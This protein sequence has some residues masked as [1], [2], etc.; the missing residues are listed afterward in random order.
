[1][2]HM[3]A[4][5]PAPESLKDPNH[6][7]GPR[8]IITAEGSTPLYKV[9]QLLDARDTGGLVLT[10]DGRPTQYV[11][12]SLLASEVV[13]HAMVGI[14]GVGVVS[15]DDIVERMRQLSDSHISDVIEVIGAHDTVVPIDSQPVH[16]QT[17]PSSLKEQPDRVFRVMDGDVLVGWYLNRKTVAE[18][19]TR[20]V[21]FVCRNGH[22][23]ADPD[24]GTCY[25]CPFPVIQVEG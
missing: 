10:E 6:F 24:H 14:E 5:K 17:N 3:P 18:T 16:S 7:Y 11:K 8:R 23:N 9:Y 13:K 20:K 15:D 1:M 4:P 19:V 25:R 21:W 2:F 22:K 12:T